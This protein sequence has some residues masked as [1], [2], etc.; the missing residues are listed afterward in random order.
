MCL[1]CR[2][3]YRVYGTTKR[4]KWK[5]ERA[6]FDKE[7]AELRV[8]EDERRAQ[9]GLAPLAESLEELR[10]WE[11]SIIDEKVPLP[12][13]AS[14][15]ARSSSTS[16]PV[17]NG[18]MLGPNSGTENHGQSNTPTITG[19]YSFS[20]YPQPNESS[21]ISS[22]AAPPPARMCTVSHCHKILP[23]F[24][25]YKRCEQHRLQNRYHSKLKRG[26]EKSE[27]GTSGSGADTNTGI[28]GDQSVES[29]SDEGG[30]EGSL[31]GGLESPNQTIIWENAEQISQAPSQPGTPS[32]SVPIPSTTIINAEV[33]VKK[34]NPVCAAE[35]CCNLLAVGVR[36]RMCDE[37]KLAE[38]AR[39]KEMKTREDE[40]Y[41]QKKKAEAQRSGTDATTTPAQ[42]A[43][44]ISGRGTG[45][46]MDV[47]ADG[48]DDAEEGC[49][50]E[51]SL[52]TKASD[53]QS[54]NPPMSS[55]TAGES[56]TVGSIPPT[57]APTYTPLSLSAPPANPI[58]WTAN[59]TQSTPPGSVRAYRSR[60]VASVVDK[61]ILQNPHLSGQAQ[62]FT[63]LLLPRTSEENSVTTPKLPYT[64]TIP[65]TPPFVYKPPAKRLK[66][67][68][69]G[70]KDQITIIQ[71]NSQPDG[72]TTR[73]PVAQQKAAPSQ[74]Q[75]QA[76]QPQ[77]S[78]PV[79]PP[80]EAPKPAP[81]QPLIPSLPHLPYPYSHLQYPVPY[82][83]PPYGLPPYG[84]YPAV[85][86]ASGYPINPAQH[87][88]Y[89]YPHQPYPYGPPSVFAPLPPGYGYPP[90]IG[91]IPN[92]RDQSQQQQQQ[93]YMKVAQSQ[94]N[95]SQTLVKDT[96]SWRHYTPG[97]KDF[98]GKKKWNVYQPPVMN[99]TV[100]HVIA[101]DGSSTPAP[102]IASARQGTTCNDPPSAANLPEESTSQRP[103]R[104]KACRRMIPT[105]ISGTICDRCRLRTKKQQA[106]AKQRYKLE[107]R[108]SLMLLA[109]RKSAG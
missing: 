106:K 35:G 33:I 22:T 95:S 99:E 26:R 1:A 58:K 21:S 2:D 87:I 103:C 25:R 81:N 71:V 89:P 54:A 42:P 20:P 109:A 70:E 48:E 91:F 79:T 101:G 15:A 97:V 78:Q 55:T 66:Q 105:N 29:G 10:A 49:C 85:P 84:V 57:L 108:K 45:N 96:T 64:T 4:A 72:D 38:R 47:D 18:T 23:G 61:F 34:R 82:Y 80:A 51:S 69:D 8:K 53:T 68:A 92:P 52:G 98:K 75:P 27:K 86:P 28:K 77:T 31:G 63:D 39:K 13:A 6:A 67:A 107:P 94:I 36:W 3:R 76:S 43:Q 5:A 41:L 19:R 17:N 60:T 62:V 37:C 102:I 40:L 32:V 44:G 90:S 24:Y 74:S 93:S 73:V 83:M 9:A 16:L 11:L 100:A 50:V 56:T 14:D 30:A 46:N 7:L 59:L 65:T 104:T 88:P 12:S